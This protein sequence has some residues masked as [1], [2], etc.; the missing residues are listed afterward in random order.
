MQNR[1]LETRQALVKDGQLFVKDVD[2]LKRDAI[3]IAEDVREHANAHVMQNKQRVTD[4]LGFVRD[5]FN[6][7]PWALVGAG[8]A[9]GIFLG[10][11]LRRRS[12]PAAA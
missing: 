5:T 2:K 9:V 8:V 11:A 12:A 1:I 7:N 6:A 4:T 10:F 3:Q